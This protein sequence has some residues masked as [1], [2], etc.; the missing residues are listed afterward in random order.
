M[1]RPNPDDG[2]VLEITEQYKHNYAAWEAK[3]REMTLQHATAERNAALQSNLG[4][5]KGAGVD[6]SASGAAA[7]SVGASDRIPSSTMSVAGS[8]GSA[9][10]PASSASGRDTATGESAPSATG[11]AAASAPAN[12]TTSGTEES[13]KAPSRLKKRL[14]V[15]R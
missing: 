14:K 11:H 5:S 13:E 1:S 9:N 6:P 10:Q 7:A 12:V 15:A 4:T 8:S 2:L 3:A